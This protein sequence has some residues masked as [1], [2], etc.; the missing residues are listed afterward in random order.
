[1]DRM[2]IQTEL[3][4]LIDSYFDDLSECKDLVDVTNLNWYYKD[5]MMTIIRE[6]FE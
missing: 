2:D 3:E 1:M 6:F 5:R 4:R